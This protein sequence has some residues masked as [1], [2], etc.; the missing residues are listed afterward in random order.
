MASFSFSPSFTSAIVPQL[1]KILSA[2]D[3][4]QPRAAESL[5]P[6]VY[7]ELR[8]LAS[9]RLS[10]ESPGQSL[11]ATALV[12]EAFLKLVD[13][14]ELQEFDSKGHFFAAAAEAMRRILVDRARRKRRP[15]H[16]GDHTQVNVEV[17]EL[18]VES[19]PNQVLAIH[20]A[21]ENF[22]KVDPQ[23]AELVKLRYFA[24]MTL[25]EAAEAMKISRATAARYW[26]F[27]KAWLAAELGEESQ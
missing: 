4:G 15:K 18:P 26:T 22:E 16:G 14:D 3:E 2:I 12:H 20:A 13:G 8:K 11:Q 9:A 6:V 5:L 24:G 21:L 25:V 10:K 17:S 7:E 23:K 27:S 19:N 1:S